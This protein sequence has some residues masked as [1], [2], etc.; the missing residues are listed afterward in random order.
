MPTISLCCITG[1]EECHVVRFLN[2][3]AP[4][5]DEFCLVRAVANNKHDR[6]VALA[7]EW[8][9]KNG[10]AFKFAE[11]RNHGWIPNLPPDLDVKGHMPQTW[12]HVDDFAAARNLSWSLATCDWQLWAD[13]DDVLTEGSANAIR[14]CATGGDRFGMFY[15]TYAIRTSQESNFR[16]RM[17]KRGIAQWAQPIHENCRVIG[18]EDKVKASYETSVVFSHEPDSAKQR[19]PERN[20]RI[21]EYHMRFADAFPYELHREYF[22]KWQASKKPEDKEAATR[23]AEIAQN[24]N[25]PTEQRVQLLMNQAEIAAESS[26][27]AAID[28]TWAALRL[29]PWLRDPWGWMAEYEIRLGRGKR[30]IFFSQVMGTLQR[31]PTTGFPT[32]D[33]FYSW[34]GLHLHTRALRLGGETE[35]A[36]KFEHGF[37]EKNGCRFSLLHATRGR[38]EQALKA[39]EYFFKAAV[40]P[41]GI[42]HIFAIDPDDTESLEKLKLYRHVVVENPNGCVKAWNAAAEACR[43][44]VML[45]LS[46]DWLP[47]LEWDEKCWAAFG[48]VSKPA[49]LAVSDNRRKDA[50]MCMAILTRARYEQQGKEVFSPEYF[51]VYSDNEFS[52]RAYRD[53][54]V[55]DA[56]KSVIFQ[57]NHP[58]FEGK[59]LEQMDATYQRQNAQA[60]YDE[61]RAIFERRNPDAK[62]P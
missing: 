19:D 40:C 57:H 44:H 9:E 51:G 8:C 31:Q 2:S 12:R 30:A 16:E 14:V 46:D 52:F 33:V 34:R 1:N 11:Y 17:F 5:F 47:C 53:G 25:T 37:F 3:F 18:G 56:R 61:G 23:W 45:Q 38:P 59:S 39:R 21:L 35:R 55:I 62:T 22:Y 26:L 58:C 4:A 13:L 10:K 49:V 7:K 20:C 6:T 15:F 28:I 29:T 24:V 43:G 42:E 32:S 41:L 50:L 60:R 36:E 48:D 54:V 27:D